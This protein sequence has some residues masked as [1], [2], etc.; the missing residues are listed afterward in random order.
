MLENNLIVQ[1][2]K[3]NAFSDFVLQI[4]SL[5][6][7][8]LASLAKFNFKL[9]RQEISGRKQPQSFKMMQNSRKKK[10]F[11]HF[12]KASHVVVIDSTVKHVPK[13]RFEPVSFLFLACLSNRIQ[14]STP[15][16][17]FFFE[18]CLLCILT[19]SWRGANYYHC[20][21][22]LQAGALQS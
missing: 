15:E 3:T 14:S 7:S 11:F 20:F 6:L 19:C 5:K 16:V 10:R 13:L 9:S 1:S 21:H 2:A 22:F 4:L 18:I 17:H 12:R 8:S